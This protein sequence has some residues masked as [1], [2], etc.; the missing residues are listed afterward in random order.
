MSMRV[1]VGMIVV[2]IA[3]LVM[4]VTVR[5]MIMC[6]M[7][8]RCLSVAAVIMGSMGMRGTRTMA[9]GIGTTFGIERRLDLDDARAEALHHS[10]DDMIAPDPQRLAHDL[11][12]QMTIAEMPGETNQM[13]R[14]VTADFEQ[15]LRRRHDFDE[16]PI[17]QNQRIAAAQRYGSL[18]VEQE[19]E[20]ACPGHGHPSPM[21][22]VKIEH[23]SIDRRLR[24]RVLSQNLRRA[25]HLTASPPCRR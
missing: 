24:P 16:T 13:E 18:E 21:S 14:I 5:S 10:L 23:D 12:R 15:W 19:F 4:D 3:V 6:A 2:M 25:D 20:P 9:G 1:A 11:R 22:V 7:I 8:M 17:L